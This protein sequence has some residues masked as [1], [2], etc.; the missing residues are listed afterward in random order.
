MVHSEYAYIVT[1][2]VCSGLLLK[3]QTYTTPPVR[4]TGGVNAQMRTPLCVT[5]SVMVS[6]VDGT[7]PCC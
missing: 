1:R 6:S 2:A 7:S 3:Q 4:A 5:C